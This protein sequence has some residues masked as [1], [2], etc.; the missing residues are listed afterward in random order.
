MKLGLEERGVVVALS[1][2]PRIEKAGGS[3]TREE[4]FESGEVARAACLPGLDLANHSLGYSPCFQSVIQAQTA[5]VRV[6]ANAF[7]ASEVLYLGIY[8]DVPCC[9]C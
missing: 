5:N 7:D 8:F 9:H 1:K 4:R 6:S 3:A 2:L